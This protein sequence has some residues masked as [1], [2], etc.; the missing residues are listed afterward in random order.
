MDLQLKKVKEFVEFVGTNKSVEM[1]M[2]KNIGTLSCKLFGHR[3]NMRKFLE[4]PST[5]EVTPIDHC[6]HCGIKRE[7]I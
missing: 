2:G 1:Y 3:M 6:I 5:V 4:N 7:E